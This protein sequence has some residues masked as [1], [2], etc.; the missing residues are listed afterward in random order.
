MNQ[1]VRNR[2]NLRGFALVAALSLMILLTVIAVGLLSLSAVSLRSTGQSEHRSVARANARMAL[3]LAMGE[4]QKQLGPDQRISAKAEILDED[5]AT[6]RTDG[7]GHPNYLGVWDSWNTWLTDKKTTDDNASL[8]IQETYQRGRH[9]SLFRAWLVSHADAAKYETA[10]ATT[11]VPDPVVLCGEKS[12]GTTTMPPVTASRIALFSGTMKTGS[13]AW[14]IDDESQKCRLDLHQGGLKQPAA[15]N[16]IVSAQVIAS[17]TGRPGIEKMTGMD[18]FDTQP[19][20]LNKMVTTGQAGISANGTASHFHDLT[21]YSLGL[22]TDVR[23]GGFK[24]DL[25]LAFESDTL[26]DEMKQTKLFSGRPYDAPIRPMTGE[27]NKIVPQNPYVAPMSWRQM[28]EYYR[29]YR[30]GFSDSNL[31]KPP[32]WN[33]G[34]PQ[35]RRFVMGK[36]GGCNWDTKGYARQLVMLRQTWVLATKSESNPKTPGGI[37]YYV[38][39]I[40]VLYL[41]N[42]YNITMQVDSK[43]ISSLGSMYYCIGMRQRT[44]R[45]TTLAGETEF[46]EK[47]V[48]G[49]PN[50][51]HDLKGRQFGYRMIPTETAGSS[52]IEFQPGEV[53]VF[54][55]NAAVTPTSS[56]TGGDSAMDDRNF[57]ATPGYLPVQD[58]QPGVLRGLKY[59]V[60]PGTGTGPLSLALR[61]AD[62]EHCDNVYFGASRHAAIVWH[63]QEVTGPNNGAFYEDGSKASKSA[64]GEWHDIARLGVTS[65]DWLTQKE[66]NDAWV[67]RDDPARR[68][69]WPPPGSAPMP[70][71]IFSVVAKSAERLAYD[72]RSGYAGDFRNRSWLHAPPTRLA[73]FLMNPVNLNR[74]DSPYQLHFRPVNGYQ[75]VSE[76]L[77]ADGK[78]GYFGGG[79]TPANGQ[80]HLAP[81]HI[82]VAPIINLASFAG[83]RMDHARAQ[84]LQENDSF[85]NP[86]VDKSAISWS[87]YNHKHMAHAG[88]A[89]GAGIGN[90]YAH[91]MIEPAK[92]YTRNDFGKDLGWQNPSPREATKLPVCDDYWDHLFLANEGLWDSWFC[93]GLVPEVRNGS[94]TVDQKTVAGNFFADEAG[95]PT[96][97][98]QNLQPNR[99]GKTAGELASLSA[100][101]AKGSNGWETISSYLFNKG[102]FNVNS[103]SKEAWKALLLSL[104]DRPLA[105]ADARTGNLT[106]TRDANAARVSRLPLANSEQAGTGPGDETAWRGIRSLSETQIDTLA[107]EIV[108]QVKLRGPFLNMTEFI[109]RRLASDATGVTGALQAAIDWDEYNAGYDG[110]VTGSGESINKA[111]KT[112]DSMITSSGL[113]ATYPNAKAACGSRYA[114]IPG[115]VMQSDLLQGMSS[116]LSPR[117]DTFLIRAYGESLADGRVA[118]SAWCEAVFQRQPEYLDTR[119]AADRK[120]RFDDGT[121][122]PRKQQGLLP[123]NRTFGRQFKMVSFRWLNSNEI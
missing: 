119:D 28:R 94:V 56:G 38:L 93:S 10:L 105:V 122:D 81:L 57:H 69:Q 106:V 49:N 95:K 7:V 30:S 50:A 5:P 74:A 84:I 113:P 25:N 63:N 120:M 99:R 8:S 59:Q 97:V 118:A 67:I 117:G 40:P 68:A 29:L 20:S 111:Y 55:T 80:T 114:G 53:R 110:S 48:P 61:L 88:A 52:P 121:P 2:S 32:T 79:Y 37:D 42:P 115:Y 78:N 21:A 123:A 66:V 19:E 82:P 26:P 98:S 12:A 35:T 15:G 23:A 108:R 33:R 18:D 22:L 109:N 100:S 36:P 51:S 102:Q 92:V 89:F 77:Q 75:E 71:G 72:G 47:S 24:S 27:I 1:A 4:L 103:T 62:A 85:A 96:L 65:V 41:W 13:Y 31:M 46:P 39:A 6:A 54:S 14:W 116:S 58:T 16:D 17:H 45:G 104:R 60:N 9:P 34:K 73:N 91:P 76:Y 83:I 112:G 43:E 70:V 64:E 3:I 87:V 90:A 101:T 44:Y 86:G 11:T 107:G